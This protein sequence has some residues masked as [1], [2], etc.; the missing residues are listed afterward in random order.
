MRNSSPS[1]ALGATR[2]TLGQRENARRSV[3]SLRAV[4][5]GAAKIEHALAARENAEAEAAASRPAEDSGAPSAAF[6]MTERANL[7]QQLTS[8]VS[9]LKGCRARRRSYCQASAPTP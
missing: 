4:A 8:L 9:Q 5:R 7:L 3:T 6:G 2:R 1:G